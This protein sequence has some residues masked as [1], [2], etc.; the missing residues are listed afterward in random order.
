MQTIQCPKCPATFA[1]E[2]IAIA[3]QHSLQHARLERNHAERVAADQ[4][5]TAAYGPVR[6]PASR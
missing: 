2:Y 6:P 3:R 4:A 5:A 1:P